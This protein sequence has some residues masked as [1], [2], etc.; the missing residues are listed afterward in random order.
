MKNFISGLLFKKKFIFILGF[1]LIILLTFIFLSTNPNA[2]IV[3]TFPQ[4]NSQNIDLGVNSYIIFSKS[5]S[6]QAQEKVFIN[7]SPPIG[8]SSYWS[9]DGKTLYLVPNSALLSGTAYNLSVNY[10]GG[11]YSWGFKTKSF[12]RVDQGTLDYNFNKD[13]QDFYSLHPWY[14]NLPPPN[15]EFFI[16]FESDDKGFF[17]DLYPKISS[18]SSV[19]D[20]TRQLKNTVLTT[21]G[22]LGVDLSKYKVSW[23]VSPR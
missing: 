9:A 10:P 1:F 3:S 20:Q 19:E 14:K 17:V 16:G 23:I 8:F 13:L 11:S 6:K 22:S 18:S 4:P 5:L 21:L 12:L 15:D 7:S 2:S